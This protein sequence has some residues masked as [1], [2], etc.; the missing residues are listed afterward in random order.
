MSFRAA[1]E[2]FSA[3]THRRE[4]IGAYCV[5]ALREVPFCGCVRNKTLQLLRIYFFLT[6]IETIYII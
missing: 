1:P 2:R 3:T 5:C 4:A 6:C